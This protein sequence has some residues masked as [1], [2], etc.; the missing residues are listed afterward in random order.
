LNSVQIFVPNAPSAILFG[1]GGVPN[2]GGAPIAWGQG[3]GPRVNFYDNG[4][5]SFWG[6]GI[7]NSE[8]Y[9]CIPASGPGVLSI[10]QNTP[11]GAQVWY[12]DANGFMGL[13]G[14]IRMS[15]P[16]TIQ[17]PDGSIVSPGSNVS[18][19]GAVYLSPHA[20]VFFDLG[21]GHV[22]TCQQVIQTSDPNLK[23]GMTVFDD[24]SCMSR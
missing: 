24:A 12:V 1:G 22:V 13:S 7:N 9:N 10:R 23:S 21:V 2:S 8:M 15:G 16:R 3:V 6:M 20:Y 18:R 4:G 5:G 17:W 19:P 14:D 11:G